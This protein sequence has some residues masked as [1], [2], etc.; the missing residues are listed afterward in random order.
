MLILILLSI[1]SFLSKDKTIHK[2]LSLITGAV[3]IV[4]LGLRGYV[5]TDTLI[6]YGYY[7]VADLSSNFSYL[8]SNIDS[9]YVLYMGIIKS[10]GF[11][12]QS[13]VFICVIIDFILLTIIFRN[14]FT[15]KYFPFFIFIFISFSGLEY[16]INLFR[17]V[18]S[19]LLFLISI[20]Y[21]QERKFNKYFILNLIGLTFHWT[22]IVFFPLYFILNKKLSLKSFFVCFFVGV[23]IYIF[24]PIFLKM[25]L[26]LIA[27]LF[28]DFKF[29]EKLLMYLELN[30]YSVGKTFSFLDFSLII[31]Y[32]IIAVSYN[33]TINKYPESIYFFN[34]FI[35]YFF[36][37]CLS[38]AMIIFRQRIALLFV[39]TCWFLFIWI[40]MAERRVIK[41]TIFGILAT[42][43]LLLLFR[44]TRAD[45]LYQYDNYLLSEKIIPRK[46][47]V[48]IYHK[49]K[50]RQKE[51]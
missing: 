32:F 29:A 40:I 18:K 17:N 6:Y 44:Q 48:E 37:V 24:A 13:F 26:N 43:G 3:F 12:Y 41:Y 1:F 51:Q 9:G 46:E 47:R 16:E 10:L 19:I 22:S 8:C 39:P 2:T 14:Y 28:G 30:T 7:R 33:K 38:S 45:I 36:A 35:F 31:F 25:F 49:E 21:I 4:F 50:L 34:L 5:Q 11:S 15:Y 42:Y 20:R 23:G 27:S